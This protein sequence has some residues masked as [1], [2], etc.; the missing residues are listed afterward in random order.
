MKNYDVAAYIWPAYT[1]D[2]PRTRIF[3]E[4]GIGEWQTVQAATPQYPGEILPRHPQ[5][6]YQNEADPD[7]MTFQIRQALSHGVNVFI[8]DWYWYDSR[9]FLEQC[10]NDGFLKSEINQDMKFYIMWANHDAT[11]TWDRRNSH[12]N[13]VIWKG[14][15]PQSE[16]DRVCDR[17]ISQY[18][19]RPNYY[20]ING[21]PV[22]MIYDICNLIRGLGGVDN[23]RKALDAFREKTKA[24]GFPNLHLQLT[25]W[26]ENSVNISGVDAGRT[27]STKDLVPML[28]FDSMSHYQFV[29][30]VDVYRSYPEILKDVKK[31]WER[32]DKEY[33]IPYFPHISIGWDSN[34]RFPK[35]TAP[36]MLD[37]TPENVK[38]GFEMAKEYVDTH[39]LPVPLVTVNS[40]NEWTEMSY[41]LPDDINGTGYLDALRDVFTNDYAR[42]VSCPVLMNPTDPKYDESIRLFQGCP[43]I[44]AT[45]GGRLYMGWYAG[46]TK[47]PHMDNYNLLIYSDDQG[48]TWSK[49]LVVIPSSYE[50]WVHALDIQLFTDPDGKLHVC[51]VQDNTYPTDDPT[52]RNVDGWVFAKDREHAEW[53]IVCDDPDAENPVFSEPRYLCVGFMRTKP[54]VMDNGEWLCCHYTQLSQN[55]A[56]TISSD[57]GQT[58]VRHFGAERLKTPFDETMA[59]QKA[60]GSI[61]MLSRTSLKKLAETTSYD[62]G[63]TWTESKLSDINDPSSRFY[64]SHTPSGRLLLVYHDAQEA[65]VNL[66][67]ALSEDDGATWKYSRLVEPRNCSYPDVAFIGDKIFLTYDRGRSSD[68]EILFMS[69]TEEDIMDENYV[70]APTIVSKP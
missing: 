26:G 62:H 41:L 46:G 3:W 8:Y 68:R 33:S 63:R 18:F 67:V 49:P 53:E 45:K 16:F 30:F 17:V 15:V 4:K 37:N 42:K 39:D 22:F 27:G 38:K 35:R 51:W 32:L 9:P 44:A 56:Y 11:Y 64:I 50:L 29:H 69:F 58:Y 57:K 28:G 47:E 14:S 20:K 23:T 48:K 19:T 60:D 7:V 40:W 1:G 25:I 43:T 54:L 2:E 5:W 70:F 10:L 52:M 65:R 61:R 34:P 6:G 31:E 55:Y 24:A 21:C 36:I 12:L 59:Y 13:D 66:T